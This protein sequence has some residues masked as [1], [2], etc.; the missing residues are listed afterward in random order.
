MAPTTLINSL[1][2]AI[3]LLKNCFICGFAVGACLT[4]A[5]LMAYESMKRRLQ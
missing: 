5:I 2:E 1:P 3:Q 4:P